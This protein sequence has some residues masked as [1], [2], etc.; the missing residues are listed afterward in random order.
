MSST[1]SYW[2]LSSAR[3]GIATLQGG[4]RLYSRCA[5]NRIKSKWR[6]FARGPAT[7]KNNAPCD[8][9]LALRK[10][11]RHTS[12]EE[13]DFHLQLSPEQVN[14]VLRAGESAHKIL[15]LVSRVPNSVLRFESNQLAANSPVE[16]RRGVA[17]CLQTN[18]LMF[19]VFD[20]HG[21]HACA[22]A[23]SERLF[24]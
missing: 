10:A 12:T 24:Y 20:G 8:D 14:E 11:Y 17:A 19:G 22:Q 23:V 2:I 4:Q 9:G 7:L 21:G 3:N 5:S 18:G 13:E 16:D 15:D 1:V 6:L